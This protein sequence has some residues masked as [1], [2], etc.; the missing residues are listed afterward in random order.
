MTGHLTARILRQTGKSQELGRG[1]RSAKAAVSLNDLSACDLVEALGG[2][3][4]GQY[5]RAPCPVCQPEGRRDQNA[6]TAADSV[7]G[8]LLVHCKKSDCGFTDILEAAGINA[9]RSRPW[10]RSQRAEHDV[11]R[12]S[13]AEKRARQAREIWEQAAPISGTLAETYLR[14]R[15]I[16]CPLPESLRFQPRCWHRSALRLP[17]LVALVEGADTDAIHRTYLRSDGTGKADVDPAKAMLGRCTGGAVR[18]VAGDGPLVVAEGIETALSLPSGLLEE[19]GSVW[20][21]LST[22]GLRSLLLPKEPG[23]LIVAVDGDEPGRAAARVLAQRAAASGWTVLLA[24]PGNGRDFND[25][26][27]EQA[28]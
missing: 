3:W 2:Q 24:D 21:A 19:V 5:G 11:V 25:V 4:Y 13:A 15:G 20:A 22:S 17:A 9:R 28:G 12:Q 26:L 23:R 14:C 18:L 1:H 16:T 27:R 7:N 10:E 6:L 8:R